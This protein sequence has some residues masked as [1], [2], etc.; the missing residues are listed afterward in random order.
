MLKTG[1]PAEADTLYNNKSISWLSSPPQWRVVRASVLYAIGK[2]KEADE[3]TRTINKS[4]L[5]PEERALL[6]AQ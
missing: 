2:K 1:K 5:R 3:I 4:Q 6:P